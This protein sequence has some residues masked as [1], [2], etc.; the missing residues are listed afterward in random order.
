MYNCI[1]VCLICYLY[2]SII[3]SVTFNHLFNYNLRK[4]NP[5]DLNLNPGD[6]LLDEEINRLFGEFPDTD[7][8]STTSA[9]PS[10][11]TLKSSKKRKKKSTVWDCF[12]LEMVKTTDGFEVERARCKYCQSVLTSSGKGIGHL[13]RHRLKCMASHGQVDTTR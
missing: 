3:V 11:S 9:V 1:F 4:M 7:P 13:M 12:D 6:Y 5:E 2:K 8:A 10:S